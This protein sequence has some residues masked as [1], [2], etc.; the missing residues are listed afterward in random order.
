[1]AVNGSITL[2]NLANMEQYL[3]TRLLDSVMCKPSALHRDPAAP[4]LR[5]SD[6]LPQ[7]PLP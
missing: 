5:T 7:L 1:V 2:V 6:E 4:A 3:M